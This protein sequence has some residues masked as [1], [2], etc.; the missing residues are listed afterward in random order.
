LKAISQHFPGDAEENQD[1]RQNIQSGARRRN[2]AR[3]KWVVNILGREIMQGLQQRSPL[4]IYEHKEHG[5]KRGKPQMR[6]LETE[7][8]LSVCLSRVFVAKRITLEMNSAAT[9]TPLC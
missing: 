6:A 8:C 2:S 5:K 9:S 4:M 7:N 3:H 1:R